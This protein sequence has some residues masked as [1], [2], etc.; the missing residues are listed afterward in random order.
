M[1]L[2]IVW[3]KTLPQNR[4]CPS[5]QGDRFNR[6][7]ISLPNRDLCILSLGLNCTTGV[8]LRFY[9]WVALFSL[10]L[11]FVLHLLSQDPF[12]TLTITISLS[13][14]PSHL[15]YT[16]FNSYAVPCITTGQGVLF[17]YLFLV[18]DDYSFSQ[19]SHICCIFLLLILLSITFH[20]L[21]F[22]LSGMFYLVLSCSFRLLS[23]SPLEYISP[24]TCTYSLL[25]ICAIHAL[26]LS[27]LES[28][29]PRPNPP[30]PL[31]H[32]IAPELIKLLIISTSL[33]PTLKDSLLIYLCLLL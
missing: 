18:M 15:P 28:L 26:H 12:V 16:P 1:C 11:L 5:L 30:S 7:I 31:V 22:L 4:Q 6:G 17:A 29:A 19:F 13:W 2:L 10:S 32:F 9:S 24:H 27:C 14:D 33:R 25:L 20:D 8:M 21:P 23:R 3:L